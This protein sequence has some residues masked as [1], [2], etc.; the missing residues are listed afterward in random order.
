MK[1]NQLRVLLKELSN[2]NNSLTH[3]YFVWTQ[4]KLDYNHVITENENKLTSNIFEGNAFS[5]KHNIELAKLKEEHAKTNDTL[6]NGIFTLIYTSF[7][8]YLND[9]YVMTKKINPTLPELNEGNFKNDDVLLHK[10]INRLKLNQ[11]DLENQYL[12]TLDYLRLKRNRIIHPSST[13]ISKSLRDIINKSGHLLNAFWNLK[14]PKKLQGMDFENNENANL[15]TYNILIDT[16]NIIRGIANY[17]DSIILNIFELPVF[18]SKVVLL[19]FKD[20]N[21]YKKY[22]LHDERNKKKFIGFCKSIYAFEPSD[23]DL[24]QIV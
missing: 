19:E 9:V 17:F 10:I 2:L 13:N 21:G 6:L 24:K 7:E 1:T 23:Y 16:L 18:L 14:L 3:Y 12:L 15:I 5:K 4:F 20:I 22:S 11:A 8:N